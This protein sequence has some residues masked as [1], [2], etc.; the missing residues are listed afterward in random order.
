LFSV[1]KILIKSPD[2]PSWTQTNFGN[3]IP[4]LGSQGFLS[5]MDMSAGTVTI[6]GEEENLRKG[7]MGTK[8]LGRQ[9]VYMNALL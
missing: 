8:L 7:E 4:R 5:S 3:N 9:N 2:S 6:P 1:P